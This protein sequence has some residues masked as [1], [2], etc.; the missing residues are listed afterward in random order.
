VYDIDHEILYESKIRIPDFENPDIL[1][2]E[3]FGIKTMK[4]FIYQGDIEAFNFSAIFFLGSNKT[5]KRIMKR[6]F[7]AEAYDKCTVNFEQLLM[8]SNVKNITGAWT[9]VEK[10]HVNTQAIYGSHIELSQ[11]FQDNKNNVTTLIL[12]YDKDDKKILLSKNGVLTSFDSRITVDEVISLYFFL[13][14]QGHIKIEDY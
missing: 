6:S 4:A 9:K 14:Q 7:K 13:L 10:D 2:D 1:Y 12:S 11:I 3:Y 8:A 5:A